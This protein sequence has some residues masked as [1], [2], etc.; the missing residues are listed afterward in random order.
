MKLLPEFLAVLGF[1]AFCGG[2]YLIHEPSALV[3]AG[4]LLMFAAWRLA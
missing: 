1:G 2:V 3:A 4:I